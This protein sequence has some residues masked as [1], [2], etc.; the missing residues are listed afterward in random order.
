M[1]VNSQIEASKKEVR[2]NSEAYQ[3]IKAEM[4]E[5]YMGRFILM[6]NGSYIDVYDDSDK[7]YS[8][9]C[10]QFGLGKFS[11]HEVGEEPISLGI[12]T[13]CIG[14]GTETGMDYGGV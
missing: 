6:H 1:S 11:I 2:K 5:K 7:A 3:S 12:Y 8:E 13:L 10:A 14:N 4:E 9:G